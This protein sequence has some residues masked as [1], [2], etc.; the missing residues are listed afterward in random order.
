MTAPT[1]GKSVKQAP[2]TKG[3][4]WFDDSF[5][6]LEIDLFST[7]LRRLP[8]V[9]GSETEAEPTITCAVDTF[10]SIEDF[11]LVFTN[12]RAERKAGNN[13]GEAVDATYLL[14]FSTRKVRNRDFHQNC[15]L[16][17]F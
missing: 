2:S 13:P 6:L 16:A 1:S 7:E 17:A 3:P 5:K 11:H 9:T 10:T 14:A 12:F 4:G 8:S 15:S